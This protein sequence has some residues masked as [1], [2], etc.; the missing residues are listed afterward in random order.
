MGKT[1]PKSVV[2]SRSEALA[3]QPGRMVPA[4]IQGALLS[5][6]CP[7]WCT[8]DHVEQDVAFVADIYHASDRVSVSAPAMGGGT[9]DVLEAWLTV[10]PFA[11]G[12]EAA[13]VVAFDAAGGGE[14]AE[15]SPEALE[16]HA[17]QLAAHVKKL[18]HLARLAAVA[19][20]AGGAR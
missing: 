6:P 13:P 14:V 5:I 11:H 12:P 16:A 19:R 4:R 10:Y 15:L 3:V 1:L 18:R 2:S 9:E 7:P 8:V 17:D 20:T